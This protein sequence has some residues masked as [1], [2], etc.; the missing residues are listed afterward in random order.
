MSI[1]VDVGAAR[2]SLLM[3]VIL[4]IGLE[5]GMNASGNPIPWTSEEYL[6]YV[7]HDTIEI[8]FDDDFTEENGISRGT[9]TIA[10]PYFIENWVITAANYSPAV[11]I[12]HTSAHFVVRHVKVLHDNADLLDGGDSPG[13]KFEDCSN[14]VVRD[15]IVTS[16]FYG[17]RLTDCRDFIVKDNLFQG[18]NEG[19]SRGVDATSCSDVD[20]LENELD[21]WAY[22][23]WIRQSE[24]GRIEGNTISGARIGV[25][26]IDCS[27]I[28]VGSNTFKNTISDYSDDSWSDNNWLESQ[29]VAAS[30]N[31][32]I[33]LL[34][35]VIPAEAALLA[36]GI[37]RY[38]RSSDGR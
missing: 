21:D 19:D 1:S 4:V 35:I 2:S 29:S 8:E 28:F 7:Q 31:G 10:D 20:F 25:S 32:L 17:I 24:E 3:S 13:M 37:L 14:G 6:P 36:F 22:A 30:D 26:L 27:G 12:Q 23:I 5:S 15:N 18:V 11:N 34:G 33:L 9:G 38:R 16:G